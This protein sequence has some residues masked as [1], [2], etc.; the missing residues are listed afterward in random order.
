M[1]QNKPYLDPELSLQV[2]AEELAISAKYL[3]QI[4]N[5]QF[6]Q[7]FHHF[8]NSYRVKECKRMLKDKNNSKMTLL[9]VA[10]EAGFNSKNTFNTAFKREAGMTPSEFRKKTS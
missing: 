3:S 1:Q 7:N 5:T 4:I 10:F 2:L 8:I 9:Q 6:K